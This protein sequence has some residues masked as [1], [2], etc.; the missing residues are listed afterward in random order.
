[1]RKIFLSVFIIFISSSLYAQ[2]SIVGSLGMGGGVIFGSLNP[3]MK[4]LNVE[5]KNAYLKEFEGGIFGF[6]GGGGLT[7]GNIRLGGYGIGGSKEV[8]TTVTGGEVISKLDFGYG[9]FVAGYELLKFGDLRFAIDVGIGGGSIDLNL[10]N[11][12]QGAVDWSNV[13]LPV[14]NSAKNLS[15]NFFYYQPSLVIEYIYGGF[16]KI[17]IAGDYSGI[18]NGKWKQDGEFELL[19]V[20]DMK[21]NGFSIRAGIYLGIFL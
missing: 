7:L 9:L 16:T 2:T 15:M 21:F 3:N 20:P 4:D 12:N 8:R 5:L 10:I 1:M 18:V 14:S 17:F 6:G 19:N 11:K 13:F